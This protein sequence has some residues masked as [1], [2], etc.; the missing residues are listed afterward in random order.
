[1]NRT[2]SPPGVHTPPA[3]PRHGSKY[4]NFTRR[5]SDR[6]AQRATYRTS[7]S[8]SGSLFTSSSSALSKESAAS[9]QALSPPA[10]PK[11]PAS[12]ESTRGARVKMMPI[13]GLSDSEIDSLAPAMNVRGLLP[14]P[15][16]TPSKT[17][18]K[19]PREFGS[20]A[21]VLFQSRPATLD[22]V[23]PGS[24]KTRK[25]RKNLF[26]L[27]S[28]ADNMDEDDEKI[29]IYTDSKERIPELDD[30]SDNPFV[31]RKGKGKKKAT[32]PAVR[33][34]RRTDAEAAEMQAAADRGEGLIYTF[35]GKKVLRR[36][37]N[38]PAPVSIEDFGNPQDGL[39]ADVESGDE[40]VSKTNR[41][42]NRS[43]TRDGAIALTNRRGR[44]G[45]EMEA[46]RPLP[47][48]AGAGRK[49]FTKEIQNMKREALLEDGSS[50][51]SEEEVI[52]DIELPVA[53]PRHS[54]AT[55]SG[56]HET[57]PPPTGRTTRRKFAYVATG[58]CANGQTETTSFYSWART[59][60]SSS[61]SEGV[62]ESRKR[63]GSL[64]ETPSAKRMRTE[65]HNLR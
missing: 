6:V 61:S 8:A 42:L 9:S 32:V 10:S 24:S 12:S 18:S 49:L 16:K 55:R 33:R 15:A 26:T 36:F 31:A 62:T 45:F 64:L 50:D 39:G 65:T 57:T 25:S 20:A 63:G 21:R 5:R 38:N 7:A 27:E 60:S 14:T 56:M 43:P 52:T 53:T 1:M 51:V 3:A 44:A 17:N 13:T 4:D 35:R 41:R 22:E 58:D 23:M 47:R 34:T 19:T 40:P 48:T 29:Q 37:E 59:K 30:D 54:H 11:N 2:P 28:F 46:D